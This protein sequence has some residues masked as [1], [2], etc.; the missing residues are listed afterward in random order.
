MGALSPRAVKLLDI[1]RESIEANGYPPSVREM[2]AKAGLSS[3]S[4]VTYQLKALEKAGYL[5]RDPNRTRAMVV[6]D[7]ATGKPESHLPSSEDTS[8]PAA[9][10]APLVGRIAAG[11]PILAEQHVEDV[12]SLPQQLVGHGDFF[13]LEVRGDSM[14]DAAICEGDWVVVRQQDDAGNGDIVAALLDDEATV[15]TFK[16]DGSQIWLLPHNER[17]SPIDGNH[18]S[19]MGKVV[20]VMRRV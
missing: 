4:S 2:A 6:V 19:I 17:Y 13:M 12:F 5:R 10:Q 9:V 7:P 3:P 8:S 11:G 18:A 1:I 14:I 20:A 15:K 16:R